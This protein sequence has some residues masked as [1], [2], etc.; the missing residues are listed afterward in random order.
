VNLYRYVGNNLANLS[1][2]LGLWGVQFGMDGRNFGVGNPTFVFTSDTWGDL[3]RGAA[4]TAD[5]VSTAATLGGLF[6]LFD[7]NFFSDHY[8]P[9]DWD[10]SISH[11]LGQ[12]AFGT[13]TAAFALPQGLARGGM[14]TVTHWGPQGMSGLRSGDWVMTGG[15]NVRNWAMSGSPGRY[16][17]GNSITRPVP[18]SSLKP[19]PRSEPFSSVKNFIGQRVYSP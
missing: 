9:C 10:T 1:D 2:P 11:G 12:F 3:G 19:V 18:T 15:G 4:A 6:G 17:M 8:D 13:A 16:G 14:Q 5:G 7:P